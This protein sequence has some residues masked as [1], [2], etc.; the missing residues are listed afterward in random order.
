MVEKQKQIVILGAGY[1]GMMAAIRLSGKVKRQNVELTLIN[2]AEHFVE[3]PR[4]HEVATGHPPQKRPLA[5]MLAGTG[6]QLRRGYVTGVD[7]EKQLVIMDV[8]SDQEMIAY[9]Y[10]VY[11]L[12][13]RTDRENVPGISEY[14]YTLD[15]SGPNSSEPLYDRLQNL[16]G[17]EGR[18][19][20]VGSGAT[21]IEMA[22][23]I[24]DLYPDLKL[25]VVTHGEFGAFKNE[26]VQ[27]YMR[28]A[29]ARLNVELVEQANVI[30]VEP[31]ELIVDGRE[32]INFDLCLWAGG[33]LALPLAREA[34]LQ[35]NT[36]GQILVDPA[37]RSLSHPNIYAIG[38]AAQPIRQPGAPMRMSLF[39]ALVS[40]AHA[41]DNIGRR[42]KN[43]DEKPLGFSYYGQGIALGRHDAV[44]FATFPDDQ[45]IGPLLTGRL[46]L[47]VRT[48]FVWLILFMLTVERWRPGF[49]FWPGRNRGKEAA[50]LI[51]RSSP[52]A[53][54]PTYP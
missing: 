15:A 32:N 18:V 54:K 9:D 35:V 37:L 28:Q 16:A 27:T 47:A 14:A 40:G 13:S 20:I 3:R 11:A 45:P 34:G 22:G 25:K 44:G 41:A 52:V 10:L 33:F 39:T 26:R 51:V 6:I 48:F 5:D 12:G 24:A 53:N 1:A 38:D 30:A 21:G 36:R 2:A 31:D 43:K 23:E 8:G 19:V 29:M 42:L 17:S 50:A 49:F 7:P 46:G 4:L